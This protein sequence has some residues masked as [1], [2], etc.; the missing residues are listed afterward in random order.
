MKRTLL[1]HS[2]KIFY[3]GSIH[4]H[5]QQ[6]ALVLKNQKLQSVLSGRRSSGLEIHQKRGYSHEFHSHNQFKKGVIYTNEVSF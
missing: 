3:H 4:H 1:A 6:Q 5:H 2:P